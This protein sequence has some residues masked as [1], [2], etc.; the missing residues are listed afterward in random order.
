MGAAVYVWQTS[1]DTENVFSDGC[2]GQ[3]AT[4]SGTVDSGIGIKLNVGV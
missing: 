2:A 4:T 1:L 3:L